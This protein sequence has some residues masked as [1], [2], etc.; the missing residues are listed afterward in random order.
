[1]KMIYQ[2]W[3]GEY[4]YAYVEASF[5]DRGLAER[6]VAWLHKSNDVE[7]KFAELKEAKVCETWEEYAASEIAD[8]YWESEINKRG[9]ESVK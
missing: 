4:E 7:E 9:K 3:V 5:T 1:M 6:L 2:V 8:G